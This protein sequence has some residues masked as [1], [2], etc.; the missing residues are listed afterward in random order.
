MSYGN[1]YSNVFSRRASAAAAK[2]DSKARV[3]NRHGSIGS[4]GGYSGIPA[5]NY[6]RYENSFTAFLTV[7][8]LSFN[9][10]FGETELAKRVR[11]YYDDGAISLYVN[12]NAKFHNAFKSNLWGFDIASAIKAE[13]CLMVD[14]YKH[15]REVQDHT[16]TAPLYIIVCRAIHPVADLVRLFGTPKMVFMDH[17]IHFEEVTGVHCI[18]TLAPLVDEGVIGEEIFQTE[19]Y[20]ITNG[21]WEMQRR[22]SH[23]WY[24]IQ[25]KV[26]EKLKKDS[27]ETITHRAGVPEENNQHPV[28]SS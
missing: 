24:R 19:F 11:K 7:T 18:E 20:P 10:L 16:S 27:D 22:L 5:V 15:P 14:D 23:A 9:A 4:N 1:R 21:G 6:V 8:R 28:S 25:T 3:V 13:F 12:M 17:N 2:A 26:R